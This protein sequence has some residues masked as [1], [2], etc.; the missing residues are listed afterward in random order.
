MASPNI[1]QGTLN[2]LR[3]SIIWPAF[4]SLTITSSFLGRPAISLSFQGDVT[5]QIDT[6]T[7]VV[8][9][10]EPFLRVVITAHLLKTQYL[11]NNFKTQQ[12]LLSL[13]GAGIVRADSAIMQPWYIQNGSIMRPGD[14]DFSG[15][16]ADYPIQFSGVY[17]VNSSLFA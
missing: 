4:P 7:G 9:S 14:L 13:L 8:T 2:R 11:A 10:P 12:E 1:P 6:L 15:A 3:A 16:S 5:V 17:Q